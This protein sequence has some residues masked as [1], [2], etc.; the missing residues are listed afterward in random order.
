MDRRR[1]LLVTASGLSLVAGCTQDR[2]APEEGTR[3]EKTPTPQTTTTTSPS[4][5]RGDS[6]ESTAT[7][8]SNNQSDQATPAARST[9]DQVSL[10]VYPSEEQRPFFDY[11]YVLI[12]NTG[13]QSVNMTGYT[14]EYGTDGSH[15]YTFDNLTIKPDAQVVVSSRTGDDTVFATYPPI[16][17]RFADFGTETNT[18]VLNN[19]NDTVRLTDADGETVVTSSW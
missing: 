4:P 15:S 8:E 6:P 7:D 3:T 9:S 1:F 18:S 11:E 12:T 14:L 17:H 10:A 2:E 5:S 16:Y 19:T 13:A